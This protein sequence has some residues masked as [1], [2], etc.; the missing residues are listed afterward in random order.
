MALGAQ[1]GDGVG[2]ELFHDFETRSRGRSM[3]RILLSNWVEPDS[4]N[5]R[6][7]APGGAPRGGGR[8]GTFGGFLNVVRHVVRHVAPACEVPV[9]K[10]GSRRVARLVHAGHWRKISCACLVVVVRAGWWWLKVDP[11][12]RGTRGVP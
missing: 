6:P 2:G 9:K 3:E 1:F 10:I 11:S 8:S 5:L 12:R 4:D 7:G